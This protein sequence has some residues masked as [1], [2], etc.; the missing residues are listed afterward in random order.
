[1]LQAVIPAGRPHCRL[2]RSRTPAHADYADV[3][4]PGGIVNTPMILAD[5]PF[6]RHEV[7]QPEVMLP[8]LVL[9]GFTRFRWPHGPALP[10]R[11]MR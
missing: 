6:S 4:I 5:A 9:A 1:M 2:R 11:E 10:R 7:I 8:P 3:L